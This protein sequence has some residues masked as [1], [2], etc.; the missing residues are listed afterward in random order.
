MNATPE[1][2]GDPGVFLCKGHELGTL[3]ISEGATKVIPW[4]QIRF[5]LE[6]MPRR[7]PKRVL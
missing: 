2:H 6:D 4:S 5:A 3:A 7:G 1:S